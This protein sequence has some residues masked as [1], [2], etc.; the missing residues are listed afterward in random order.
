MARTNSYFTESAETGLALVNTTLEVA[1]EWVDGK[2]HGETTPKARAKFAD[3]MQ[4]A[5]QIWHCHGGPAP[6]D[7]WQP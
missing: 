3:M 2:W 6:L 4:Q 7:E 5:M 1:Q